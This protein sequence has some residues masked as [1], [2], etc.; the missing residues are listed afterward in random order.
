MEDINFKHYIDLLKSGGKIK[1]KKV[2]ESE[3]TFYLNDEGRLVSEDEHGL[4]SISGLSDIELFFVVD[5]AQNVGDFVIEEI[6]TENNSSEN[7]AF[8]SDFERAILIGKGLKNNGYSLDD[9]Y[10]MYNCNNYVKRYIDSLSPEVLDLFDDR[11]P[12]KINKLRQDSKKE[13]DLNK[14]LENL[15]DSGMIVV[16]DP[17]GKSREYVIEGGMLQ[18]T[19]E[20]G[21][22]KKSGFLAEARLSEDLE[23]I[24]KGEVEAGNLLPEIVFRDEKAMEKVKFGIDTARLFRERLNFTLDDFESAYEQDPDF[25]YAVD[26]LDTSVWERTNHSE[27]LFAGDI[28]KDAMKSITSSDIRKYGAFD[29]MQA[30]EEKMDKG[31]L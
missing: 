16:L 31:E 22:S 30:T 19:L 12:T 17:S 15:F 8:E 3:L 4:T 5:N 10:E 6:K 20:D 18:A 21:F 7:S 29:Q 11:N 2:D 14:L 26:L 23:R 28:L 27:I 1:S 25:R 9:I 13:S 24:Y